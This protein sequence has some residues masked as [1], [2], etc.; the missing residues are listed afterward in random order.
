MGVHREKSLWVLKK[1]RYFTSW[2][3][4]ATKVH[5]SSFQ[6]FCIS[7]DAPYSRRQLAIQLLQHTAP[8]HCF[9]GTMAPYHMSLH[10]TKIN[11]HEKWIRCSA[12]HRYLA[13][14]D[15]RWWISCWVVWIWC[16]DLR[17]KTSAAVIIEPPRGH[18]PYK[19][20]HQLVEF[21]YLRHVGSQYINWG[22]RSIGVRLTTKRQHYYKFRRRFGPS[23]RSLA[24]LGSL[25]LRST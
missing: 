25:S 17:L 10:W 24:Q 14:S 18:R 6:G 11:V 13:Q 5:G 15:Y 19:P 21:K 7:C 2:W 20:L 4:W 8:I 3:H 9:R 16:C 1:W 23:R 12:R 22:L